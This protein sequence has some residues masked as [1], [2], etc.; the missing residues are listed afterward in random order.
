MYVINHFIK[1]NKF[2]Y[3]HAIFHTR[4]IILWLVDLWYLVD[5]NVVSGPLLLFSNKINVLKIMKTHTINT[6]ETGIFSKKKHTWR[7]AKSVVDFLSNN[8][9]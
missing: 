3:F 8:P 9:G 7:A 1:L 6:S 5:F 2:S 4:Q